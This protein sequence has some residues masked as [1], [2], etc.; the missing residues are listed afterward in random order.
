M[1]FEWKFLLFFLIFQAGTDDFIERR[2]S[3]Q[4]EVDVQALQEDAPPDTS[5]S[6]VA[7]AAQLVEV[8][9]PGTRRQST[10]AAAV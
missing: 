2:M 10:T 7:L 4:F 9:L 6:L 1:Y 8:R 5:A 3:D